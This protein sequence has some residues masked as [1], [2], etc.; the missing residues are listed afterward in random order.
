M[1]GA[2]IA[3]LSAL[4]CA[5]VAWADSWSPPHTQRYTSADGNIQAVIVPRALAGNFEYLRDKVDG[6]PFAGQRLGSNIAEAF[7]QVSRRTA[8]GSWITLWRQSLVNDVAPMHALV[9]NSGKYLITFDNW[10]HRG[11][12][13][14]AVVIYDARGRLIRKCALNDF[15]PL[16]Y[17]ETLPTTVS[18]I[19]WGREHFLFDDEETLILRVVEPSFR[20]GDDRGLTVSV[21]ILLYDGMITPPAGRG[22]ERALRKSKKVRLQQQAYARKACKEWGGG[23]CKQ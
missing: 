23:W 16:S 14:D 13:T 6:K 21:R 10:H 11:Y 9:A 7:A 5:T 8:D 4:L 1:R 18:S 17:I 3:G 2:S 19:H 20:F 15:L 12:G 22:W